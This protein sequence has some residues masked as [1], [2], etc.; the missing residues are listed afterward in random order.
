MSEIAA[1]TVDEW[2]PALADLYD[3]ER[4]ELVR[5]AYLICGFR[6]G[7]EDAVHD[8][9]VRVARR[10]SAVTNGRSYLY[11]A[12]VNAA[13]DVA[14][15]Q[16]RFRPLT[17]FRPVDASDVADLSVESVRL[18]DALARLNERQRTAIVLRHYADWNDA[19]IAALLG[20]QEAT[21]RSLIHRG[22]AR[23]RQELER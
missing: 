22:I 12:V 1:E 17:H 21:V 3:T 8:A 10:W 14:R 23:I 20:A 4:L 13:R 6:A 18:R 9:V 15:R 7:A 5:T 2:P 19:E 11:T 16:R